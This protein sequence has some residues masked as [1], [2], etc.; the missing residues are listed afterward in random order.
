MFLLL[1]S[2]SIWATNVQ[3]TGGPVIVERNIPGNEIIVEFS[4]GW[5]NSWNLNSPP[6]HDAAWVFMKYRVLGT[7]GFTHANLHPEEYIVMGTDGNGAGSTPARV[8]Y[9]ASQSL[10]GTPA[11]VGVFI[12][13]SEVSVGSNVFE[14]VRLHWDISGTGIAEETVLSVRIFAIE[15]V[16]IPLGR[17]H[18][19]HTVLETGEISIATTPTTG[20]V[21]RVNHGAAVRNAINANYDWPIGTAPFYIMKHEVTQ[22][23]WVDF[24][25]SLTLEQQMRLSF[26]NPTAPNNTRFGALHGALDANLRTQQAGSIPDLRHG[27]MNIRIRQQAVGSAPA[28]FGVNANR[29]DG[30]APTATPPGG[31]DHEINGGNL[32]MF[33]LNWMDMLAYLDWAGLRPLTELEY[34]K[35]ARGPLQVVDNEFAW[36]NATFVANLQVDDGNLPTEGPVTPGANAAMVHVTNTGTVVIGAIDGSVAARWPIRVGSFARDNTTR[37]QAGASF[38]GVLNLSDNVA[39]RFVNFTTAAGQAFRGTHGDGNLSGDGFADNADWPGVTAVR[40]AL[41]ANPAANLFTQNAGTA[42]F[43]WGSGFR[44]KAMATNSWTVWMRWVSGRQEAEN[45][46]NIRSPWAGAR[47]GRSVPL[48]FSILSNPSTVPRATNTAN[49]VTHAQGTVPNP[50][51][52]G[53]NTLFIQAVGGRPP[54]S[55]QW[56]WIEGDGL[57]GGDPLGTGGGGEPI[58]GATTVSFLPSAL[59]PHGPRHFFA[60]VTDSDG[61][62]VTSLLSGAHSVLGVEQ[63]PSLDP[64]ATSLTQ[65]TV[66]LTI[67]PAGGTPP[68]TVQWFVIPNGVAGNIGAGGTFVGNAPTAMTYRPIIPIWLVGNHYTFF[69]TITDAMGVMVRTTQSGPHTVQLI[70]EGSQRNIWFGPGNQGNSF[71]SPRDN[72]AVLLA[73]SGA[74]VNPNDWIFEVDLEPGIYRL[75]AWGASGGRGGHMG[76]GTALNT[77]GTHL[78]NTHGV[79][80]WGGYTQTFWRL[81]NNETIFIVPGGS[82]MHG[83][84]YTAAGGAIDNT[85]PAV[86]IPGSRVPGGFNGGGQGGAPRTL[87]QRQATSGGGGG[88]ATHISLA[89]GLL[90]N[91]AVRDGILIV[92][93]G[94]GGGA[95]AGSDNNSRVSH[96]GWIGL[97]GHVHPGAREGIGAGRGASPTEPGTAGWHTITVENRIIDPQPGSAGRGGDGGVGHQ[98]ANTPAVHAAV[99]QPV[100]GGG[101]GGGW[102]GGG[103]GGDHNRHSIG[104]GGGSG[105]IAPFLQKT[106]GQIHPGSPASGMFGF[107]GAANAVPGVTGNIHQS[108]ANAFGAGTPQHP[109]GVQNVPNIRGGAVRIIRLQ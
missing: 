57:S 84:F 74:N 15:M 7:H 97:P 18:S 20:G 54:L 88:G 86:G 94:G 51:T 9:G 56:Y 104:G 92:A 28:V 50:W 12:S 24:L 10:D 13:R 98:I 3:F 4:F 11:Y 73:Q 78:Q 95:H 27:R 82:G 17:F 106:A 41:N 48:D 2:G 93:G 89:R 102:F 75:E 47:G 63:Q 25:N 22:H 103:G 53:V 108:G 91:A 66:D 19:I 55:V 26:I 31:W 85:R 44:G 59:T 58:D 39:E 45:S 83:Y 77:F 65:G 29:D 71:P 61:E 109:Q 90:D 80:G 105:H 52:A 81:D 37:V 87:N 42:G 99:P 72:R 62:V 60:R 68:F 32:P 43:A 6:N 101:G 23:A 107:Q 1:F 79:G 5:D 14:N 33:G 35:A 49:A 76:A 46:D 30:I 70:S 38:W 8:R 64:I 100:F 40:T 34:E 36:G 69:A 96:Q 16:Y 67:A 21:A